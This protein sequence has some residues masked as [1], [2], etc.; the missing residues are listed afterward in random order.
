VASSIL[1]EL[2]ES[3][4]EHY[5]VESEAG[6]GG[7]ATVFLAEDL[8]HGRRVAIKVLS[9]ELSS[10]L[11]GDRFKREIQIAA[12]LS[13]PHIL[14]VFDSGDANGLL[15]YVMPFVEGESLR[16]K[17]KRETQLSIDDAI[18]I[19][20]EVADAL[21]YAHSFG[22]V[23]RDIK[24]EN[25]LLNGGHAVVADFGIAR[26]IQDAGGEKLT[27][28]G[29]SVGTASYMSPEQF[30]GENV[31]GRS[32]LYSLA[33]VLYEMLVG[34]V[35]FTG[36]NAIAIMARHTMEMPPSIQIV[37]G[38]VPDE[39]EGA[40]MHA[41]EKVPAD[42][43]ATVAQFKD[44]LLGNGATSTY[45]RRTRAYTRQHSVP[46]SMGVRR[47]RWTLLVGGIA[48]ALLGSGSL[49]GRYYWVKS[50]TGMV[51]QAGEAR[52][53][54]PQRIAV[55]Y[56]TDDSKNGS[57]AHVASGLTE[58]LIARLSEVEGLDVVSAQGVS[59][60]QNAK[61]TTDSI[62]R[63]LNAGTLVRGSVEDDGDQLRISAQ[64]VDGSGTS[65][66]RQSFHV[67]RSA[68]LNARDSLAGAV[69]D[70]LRK[71]LGD[72]VRLREQRSGTTNSDAWVLVQ[73]VENLRKSADSL[74]AASN[75]AGATTV[76][77]QADS[78]DDL[79]TKLD[80]LWAEPLIERGL[81]SLRRARMTRDPL[82]AAAHFDTALA[83]ASAAIAL[84]PRS[85]N[86]Y[87][88]RGTVGYERIRS[89]VLVDQRA[90]DTTMV[91]AE[92]DL[93]HS[94]AI[95][96][97]QAGAWNE[98]SILNQGKN[99][100][101][102]ANNDARRAYEADA[103]LRAAPDIVYRLWTT[104]YDI[105]Q[106]NDA[107]YWCGVGQHRF[108]ADARFVRC[109][110]FLLWTP[111]V[112]PDPKEAWRLVEEYTRLTPKQDLEFNRREA[113]IVAAVALG[114]A[115]L[116][117]SAD[118]VLVRARAGTDID[119]RGELFGLEGVARARLGENDEAISLFQRY[120]IN[121]PDHRDFAGVNAWWWRDLRKDPRFSKLAGTG[122]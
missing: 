67:P 60:F 62:A 51:G 73:R 13:H 71:R 76:L 22:V 92:N 85:A 107:I 77:N 105:E 34:E 16:G 68:V 42:R 46:S 2:R 88:L 95:A 47:R 39:L 56:F 94:I 83:R 49:A 61:I 17:L 115:G 91:A 11:D 87:E 57:L 19:A 108:P 26:V 31:D 110:L 24:P 90:I 27:Q 29:M 25:I 117:D 66:E 45:A 6:R 54:P 50:H 101:I 109:R 98:L 64:L 55:L 4:R 112:Q 63:S 113:E 9:P 23:H 3:L 12:R 116:R 1:E 58:S 78:L 20:C 97:R 120:L 119:P 122:R 100:I 40:I 33:C 96:P 106:F 5:A 53:M 118:R 69:A 15:Y 32:D 10:S 41:L 43:F 37:R 14:P 74:I 36:P 121:H 102:E 44:A 114:R 30:G 75:V 99:N 79:A 104:S 84:D 65:F 59:P 72:E 82:G 38:T 93:R 80:G 103:Y 111:A 70:L 28:T 89:G 86:A 48:I 21:S 7:M 52:S 81:I 18:M 8:K 35:P